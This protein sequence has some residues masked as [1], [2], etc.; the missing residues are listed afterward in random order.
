MI[1]GSQPAV[2]FWQAHDVPWIRRQLLIMEQL[3]PLP[4]I[5]TSIALI[6]M[7]LSIRSDPMA[8]AFMV[9]AL[10]ALVVALAV[11][12]GTLQRQRVVLNPAR[13]AAIE[14]LAVDNTQLRAI[15]RRLNTVKGHF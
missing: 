7:V 11:A 6:F 10:G 9:V 14:P 5:M 13:R 8:W 4:S 2:Q 12:L 1:R 3:A 15:Q